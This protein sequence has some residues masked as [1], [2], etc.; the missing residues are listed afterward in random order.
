MTERHFHGKSH[1]RLHIEKAPYAL[2]E[3]EKLAVKIKTLEM[4]LNAIDCNLYPNFHA[5]IK[6]QLED[7]KSE[8]ETARDAE[9]L[10]SEQAD[11]QKLADE[12]QPAMNEMLDVLVSVYNKPSPEPMDEKILFVPNS[13]KSQTELCIEYYKGLIAKSTDEVNTEYFQQKIDDLRKDKFDP[14]DVAIRDP[15]NNGNHIPF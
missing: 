9:W 6:T 10:Q 4:I 1:R 12:M 3:A 14:R 2:T 15:S 8:I 5:T 11:A 7:A 13:A